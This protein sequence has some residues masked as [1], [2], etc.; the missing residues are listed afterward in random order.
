MPHSKVAL[1]P[2]LFITLVLSSQV[3]FCL[4]ANAE[5]VLNAVPTDRHNVIADGKADSN[6]GEWLDVCTGIVHFGYIPDTIPTDGVVYGM[7]S[8]GY[9]EEYYGQFAFLMHNIKNLTVE[10]EADYNK[11]LLHPASDPTTPFLVIFV[12]SGGDCLDDSLWLPLSGINDLN[13]PDLQNATSWND[14][15]GCLI[16]KYN[17][18]G[19]PGD[20]VQWIKGDPTPQDNPGEFYWSEYFGVHARGSFNNTAYIEGLPEATEPECEMYEVVLS[21]DEISALM[22][23]DKKKK[24]NPNKREPPEPVD[25]VPIPDIEMILIDA[26][27]PTLDNEWT[28]KSYA[29]FLFRIEVNKFDI[30]TETIDQS[31][32]LMIPRG[33]R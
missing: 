21:L 26:K 19:G 7:K 32:S 11:F 22:Y 2:S 30:D 33:R 3:V 13:H 15:E 4:Y 5:E 12:F 9:L 23:P 28:L 20:Y 18:S 25:P 10:H 17:P 31:P 6:P 27:E 16:F 1:F 14:T 8:R 24:T 29:T